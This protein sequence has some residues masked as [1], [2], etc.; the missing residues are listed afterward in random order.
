[1]GLTLWRLSCP[2]LI[3]SSVDIESPWIQC[4][5][6]VITETDEHQRSANISL[7]APMLGDNSGDEVSF[8]S[9]L[10][11]F[12][13]HFESGTQVLCIH[14]KTRLCLSSSG[15]GAG[16]PCSKPHAAFPYR[17]WAHNI[18]SNRPHRKQ[19]QLLF[20]CYCSWWGC[21]PSTTDSNLHGLI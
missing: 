9:A 15:Y 1:M 16:D 8:T 7:S 3:F 14:F 13:F 2:E 11:F 18:H 17:N 6:D 19:G 5:G 20:H 12:I 10:S 21:I 4:P